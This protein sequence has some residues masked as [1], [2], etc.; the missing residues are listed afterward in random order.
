MD[1]FFHL[2][3]QRAYY[4]TNVY[5][6]AEVLAAVRSGSTAAQAI[7]VFEDAKN[8]QI[9]IRHGATDWDETRLAESPKQVVE[10]AMTL[11]GQSE[12]QDVKFNE[13]ALVLQALAAENGCVFSFDSGLRTLARSRGVET[14]P[15]VDGCWL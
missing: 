11:I 15:Y 8:S 14:L 12:G 3:R 4:Y 13:A 9:R 5:V 10:A 2:S 6:L 1:R 7:A